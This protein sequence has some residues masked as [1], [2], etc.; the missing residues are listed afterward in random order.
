MLR[1]PAP[2]CILG[3][4][5]PRTP[6]KALRALGCNG[7]SLSLDRATCPG[8]LR[9]LVQNVFQKI[10]FI[11]KMHVQKLWDSAAQNKTSEISN[12]AR[13]ELLG[14]QI[15]VQNVGNIKN[16]LSEIIG[17]WFAEQDVGNVT[18]TLAEFLGL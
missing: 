15:A 1:P 8:Q 11:S 17:L 4:S 14:L 7:W 6:H 13:S 12:N 16:A 3:G 10:M 2:P 9:C 5:A 18:K